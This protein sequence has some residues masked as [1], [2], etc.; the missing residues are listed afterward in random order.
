MSYKTLE[1]M[2]DEQKMYTKEEKVELV[3]NFQADPTPVNAEKIIQGYY[4]LIIKT[5]HTVKNAPAYKSN[6]M[7]SIEDLVNAGVIG[8]QQGL[9]K[10][11][12]ELGTNIDSYIMKWTREYMY[13]Q[14]REMYTPV[15]LP[16]G[17][18]NASRKL[19]KLI[20]KNNGEL[21]GAIDQYF[22][23]YGDELTAQQLTK[24]KHKLRKLHKAKMSVD[25]IHSFE[26]DEEGSELQL[27]D[28]CLNGLDQFQASETL[29]EISTI[30]DTCLSNQ[31]RDV[32]S[33]Y[34]GLN[35]GSNTMSYQQIGDEMGITRM[36]ICQIVK[37]SLRKMK[38]LATDRGYNY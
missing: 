24:R 28:S 6:S 27:A 5:A 30:L 36:R 10:I 20:F 17:K 34:F 21:D 9:P 19:D 15:R 31:E 4:R 12:T 35:E 26:S 8:M 37:N 38:N 29:D 16:V 7:I 18:L 32:I 11:K 22:D 14:V 23:D 33:K 13:R 3:N 25:S 2:L 1:A